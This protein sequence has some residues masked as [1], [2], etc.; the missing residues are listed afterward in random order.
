MILKFLSKGI[1]FISQP[2]FLLS[3]LSNP[4]KN[5]SIN[6]TNE[7]SE[8]LDSSMATNSSQLKSPVGLGLAILAAFSVAI[9]TILLKKLI[10]LN[11]DYSFM[12]VYQAYIGVPI[13]LLLSILLRYIDFEKHHQHHHQQQQQ[14]QRLNSNY[15]A[16]TI[17]A[18]CTYSVMSALCV[19]GAQI[20]LKLG[21]HYEEPAKFSIIRMIDLFFT[22]ILQMFVLHIYS[23]YLSIIGA[24]LIFF[25]TFL[26]IFY[27]HFL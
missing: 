11:I 10:N 7:T 15:D 16:L 18:Q 14:Q 17:V 12:L 8:A 25:S 9:A 21:L 24:L 1:I 20:F 22:F 3:L 13:C 2:P 6:S 4:V 26:V 23:N 27:S 5:A 19:L